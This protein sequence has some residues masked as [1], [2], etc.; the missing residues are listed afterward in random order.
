MVVASATSQVTVSASL[1]DAVHPS[2]PFRGA[3]GALV[4]FSDVACP[5]ATVVV[6]RLRAARAELGLDA[7]LPIVHLAHPLE[8]LNDRLLSRRVIDA[9]IPLCASL[10]PAFGWSLW[11]GHLDEYPV[12]SQLA[13]QA[14]QAARRQSE[15][16]AEELDLT[17][18][19]AFFVKSQCISMRNAIRDAARTCDNLDVDRLLHDLADGALYEAVLRQSAAAIDGAAT[20]SGTVVL[21]DGEAVCNP[22]VEMAW[23]GRLPRGTPQLQ[24]QDPTMYRHLIATAAGSI[25][26]EGSL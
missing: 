17:L 10:T 22:G 7:Q 5:W 3:T 4:V 18:R 20:C 16:A 25:V 1:Q 14:V 13:A 24:S 23:L 9:E 21:P 26:Q 8:L 2:E 12:T 15:H 19:R 11:Q 6:L